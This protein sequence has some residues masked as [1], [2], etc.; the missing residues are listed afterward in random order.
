MR[1][2][3]HSVESN[4]ECP[5][6]HPTLEEFQNFDAYM[7][8]VDRKCLADDCGICKIIAPQEWRAKMNV[9]LNEC[10]I[11]IKHPIKQ[12]ITGRSGVYQQMHIIQ[13]RSLWVPQFQELAKEAPGQHK[14]NSLVK[15][16][17]SGDDS[18]DDCAIERL[19]WKNISFS[20]PLY[21]SDVPGSLMDRS[22]FASSAWNLNRLDSLLTQ[23]LG[24]QVEIP[25]ITKSYLY[26]G[27]WKSTFAWHVEDMNLYS[28]NY[29]HFGAPKL[30]YAVPTSKADNM[31]T[32]MAS[33]FPSLHKECSS[34]LRHKTSVVSPSILQSHGIPITRV[35]QYPGEFIV[36]MPRSYHAGFN[37]GFNCNEAVN[38]ALPRWIPLGRIATVCDCQTGSVKIDMSRFDAFGNCDPED[39][40]RYS[41][42]KRQRKRPSSTSPK[43][44]KTSSSSSSSPSTPP[45]QLQQSNVEPAKKLVATASTLTNDQLSAPNEDDGEANWTFSCACGQFEG[46][47]GR[48]PV[49]RH[50]VGHMFACSKCGLWCHVHCFDR[51]KYLAILPDLMIC[52]RCEGEPQPCAGYSTTHTQEE[53][54]GLSASSNNSGSN[55]FHHLSTSKPSLPSSTI[56]AA[57]VGVIPILTSPTPVHPVG[58]A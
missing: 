50:P 4:S 46:I 28:I 5:V 34:F 7:S 8:Y 51:Y 56:A 3:L 38:F 6:F 58:N 13:G 24:S 21:G 36:T 49:E 14:M 52:H 48:D 11:Q 41:A 44:Q 16:D 12:Y 31:E 29:H 43:K 37:F 2:G 33:L 55:P 27:T 45:P 23:V 20:Q 30:W 17:Q 22:E 10:G 47:T 15:T 39:P 42:Q 40:Q 53:Q 54:T 25:G 19:Y 35:I 9:D 32:V 26:F 18:L 57:S 1:R